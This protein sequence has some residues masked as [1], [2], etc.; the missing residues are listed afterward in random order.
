MCEYLYHGS[1]VPG[2]GQIRAS[3]L[4]H[5]T[6]DVK[7]V[8][9]TGSRA[10]ALFYIWDA[11]HNIRPG[12]HVTA[13]IRDGMVY[14]EEQFPEQLAAFYKGVSGYVYY[15]ERDESFRPVADHE[16][17]WYNTR[18]AEVAKADYIADVYEE[19]CRYERQGK[20]K[21]V[22]YNEVPASR[23]EMLYVHFAEEIVS[24]NLLHTP[25]T[26][27]ARFFQ[28]YYKRAWKL[29]A[30]KDKENRGQ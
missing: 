5:G 12:K 2:I 27:N 25:D 8:Y 20:L 15:V 10:Y 30:E 28:T 16:S 23:I 9:L 1:S 11:E 19:I 6:D 18:D 24:K 4:L 14:Y 13:W 17:M 3:S 21:V 26:A 7:V 22:R 29:A